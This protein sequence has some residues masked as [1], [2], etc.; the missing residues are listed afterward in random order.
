M[1][2][3]T[4]R[5]FAPLLRKAMKDNEMQGIALADELGV[6]EV[7]ISRWRR[8]SYESGPPR[9]KIRRL[10]ERKLGIPTGTLDGTAARRGQKRLKTAVAEPRGK[11]PTQGTAEYDARVER[12]AGTVARV[13]AQAIHNA[14]ADDE[15]TKTREGQ[16]AIARALTHF[17]AELGDAGF[18]VSGLIR[19]A[20]LLRE[21][22]L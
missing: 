20:D 8:D 13:I 1:A 6:D 7:T 12:I 22:Q 21:G 17:A 15:A 11:G 3:L 19:V 14:V 9:P 10:L 5:Q 2:K 4:Q 18:I 16:K